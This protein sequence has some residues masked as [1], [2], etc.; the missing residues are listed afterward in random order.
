MGKP[1]SSLRNLGKV[2]S[3]MLAE[4]DVT[5]EDELRKIGAVSAYHRLKFQFGRHI[6]LNALY[7]ME[8]ALQDCDWRALDETVKAKLRA[9]AESMH[10]KSEHGTKD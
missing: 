6:S 10:Q 1:V 5:T 8:A 2:T 7:A 9:Q 3:R 4:V